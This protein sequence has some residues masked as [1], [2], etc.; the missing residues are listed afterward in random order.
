MM[1]IIDMLSEELGISVKQVKRT[2]DLI[3]KGNT[4]PFIARYRKEVT[5]GVDDI[6]LRELYEK[7]NYLRSLEER[8]EDIIRLI[9]E[10]DKLTD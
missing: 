8:R 7:L 10:Q 2:V 3:D 9:K 6:V 4:I 5:G 1:D